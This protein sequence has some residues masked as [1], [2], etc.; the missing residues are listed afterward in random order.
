VVELAVRLGR[1][2]RVSPAC[3]SIAV[4]EEVMALDGD[5]GL[6][7]DVEALLKQQETQRRLKGIPVVSG[8]PG[9]CCGS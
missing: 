1:S 3:C 6:D 7:L 5:D 4:G 2:V 9:G 8:V